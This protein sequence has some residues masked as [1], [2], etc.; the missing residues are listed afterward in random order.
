MTQQQQCRVMTGKHLYNKQFSFQW[1]DFLI[2][3]IRLWYSISSFQWYQLII[4][5]LSRTPSVN[6][7]SGRRLDRFYSVG[8]AGYQWDIRCSILNRCLKKE[9]GSCECNAVVTV[10][11]LPNHLTRTKIATKNGVREKI[12]VRKWEGS[13]C[14]S[15]TAC[16][17][18]TLASLVLCFK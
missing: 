9:Q 10:T 16:N 14:Y 5:W 11:S 15:P 18:S 17:M 1:L 8:S 12:R 6:N 4:V 7:T 13:V 3:F 2:S